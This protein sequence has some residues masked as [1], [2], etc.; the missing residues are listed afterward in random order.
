M[1]LKT[2]KKKIFTKNCCTNVL[3]FVIKNEREGKNPTLC[4]HWAAISDQLSYNHISVDSRVII[5]TKSHAHVVLSATDLN[6]ILCLRAYVR[7]AW[8]GKEWR[9]RYAYRGVGSSGERHYPGAFV[10]GVYSCHGHVR[11]H[12]FLSLKPSR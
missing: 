4:L 1:L 10:Y 11:R 8:Y 7:P 5:I 3:I 2:K 9:S 12:R 6:S